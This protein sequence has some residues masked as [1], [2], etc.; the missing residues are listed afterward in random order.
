LIR[1]LHLPLIKST[2]STPTM[3]PIS[4]NHYIKMN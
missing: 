3:D 1:T 2:I 4:H